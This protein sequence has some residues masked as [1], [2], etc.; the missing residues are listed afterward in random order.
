MFRICGG[1][2]SNDFHIS[3]SVNFCS[4]IGSRNC[5]FSIFSFIDDSVSS[6]IF[7]LPRKF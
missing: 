2:K 3:K 1:V 4:K 7:K 5:H 6:I